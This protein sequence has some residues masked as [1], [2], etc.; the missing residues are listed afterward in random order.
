MTKYFNTE[1]L[2]LMSMRLCVSVSEFCSICICREFFCLF[3]FIRFE[4]FMIGGGVHTRCHMCP[5]T[6]WPYN[7]RQVQ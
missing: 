4:Y 7:V 3:V 1:F 2:L 6:P 5:N